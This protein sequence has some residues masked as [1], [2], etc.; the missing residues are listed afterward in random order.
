MGSLWKIGDKATQALMLRFYK[1]FLGQAG[2]DAV[3]ALQLA[4]QSMIEDS[5]PVHEWASFVVFGLRTSMHIAGSTI[6]GPNLREHLNI[7]FT[8]MF[9]KLR[10]LQVTVDNAMAWCIKNDV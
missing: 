5:R 1:T 4:M 9:E 7:T 10:E 8:P 6:V 2:G 3:V